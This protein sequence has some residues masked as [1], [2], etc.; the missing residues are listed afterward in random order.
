MVDKPNCGN[1]RNAQNLGD[2]ETPA[3]YCAEAAHHNVIMECDYEDTK[4]RGC[5]WHPQARE[6]LNRDVVKELER[7]IASYERFS[8]G[9]YS[10]RAEGMKHA[11]TLIKEGVKE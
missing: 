8:E 2:D 1:C 11:I 3:M 5:M 7:E 9:G 4:L 10:T 6:Y